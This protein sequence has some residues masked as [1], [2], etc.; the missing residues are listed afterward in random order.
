[1]DKLLAL[2]IFI[3]FFAT[4]AGIILRRV[5][6]D[7]C[8]RLLDDHHVTFITPD[9]RVLWGDLTVS[10]QGLELRYDAPF[11]TSRGLVKGLMPVR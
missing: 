11:V 1:M 6:K 7:K 5:F 9:G 2:T 10:G 4:L 8:L 3:L